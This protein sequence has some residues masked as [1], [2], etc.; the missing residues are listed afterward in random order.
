MTVLNYYLI[1]SVLCGN[2]RIFGTH[3]GA[4]LYHQF[5]V[6]PS[7]LFGF[8]WPGLNLS[9]DLSPDSAAPYS[10]NLLVFLFALENN[11]LQIDEMTCWQNDLARY[12][13]LIL[14]QYFST[15]LMAVLSSSSWGSASS[16]SSLTFLFLLTSPS[17]SS[18]SFSRLTALVPPTMDA[19]KSSAL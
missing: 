4:R 8:T 15:D 3:T 2:A 5:V 11:Y 16:S 17:N 1:S 14:V 10:F 19:T 6:T 7:N 13:I 12:E 9:P 18:S